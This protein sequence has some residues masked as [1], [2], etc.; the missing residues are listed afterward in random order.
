VIMTAPSIAV[1]QSAFSSLLK[2]TNKEWRHALS[3]RKQGYPAKNLPNVRT[4]QFLESSHR[5]SD[6]SFA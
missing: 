1:F 6:G 2:L 3:Y 4:A 5:A